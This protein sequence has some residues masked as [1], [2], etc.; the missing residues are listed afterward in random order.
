[1]PIGRDGLREALAPLSRALRAYAGGAT[2]RTLHVHTDAGEHQ[3]MPVALFFRSR[4]RLRTIDRRALALCGGRVL[5]VGAG[6]GALALALQADGAEVTALE[7]LPA[8]VRVMRSR[9][10]RDVRLA[11][12]RGFEPERRYDTVL[13]LMNGTAPA[14]T[15]AGLPAWLDALAA[16]LA[17][18]GQLL[19]DSTD[20][21]AP[22]EPRTR[23][24]ALRPDGRY[25]GELQYQLEYDGKRGPPFP[26]LFV[27]PDRLKRAARA[28]GLTSE[29]VWRDA[30]GAYL[31][32]LTRR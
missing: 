27:D 8:A 6:A 3:R 5:D 19:I 23:D 29:V 2:R 28:V 1:M 9:G 17:D 12:V 20:L 26:Q 18:D 31:A 7:V 13:A 21:R 16:P 32:R 11:D 30:A 24:R 4:G 15:L 10:V 25:V 14:G 22:R